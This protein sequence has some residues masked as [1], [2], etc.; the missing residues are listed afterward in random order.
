MET[1]HFVFH[2]D[3][4]FFLSRQYRDGRL[5]VSFEAGQ[6]IKHLV[7]SLGTPHTEIGAVRVNGQAAGLDLQARSGNQV[8]VFA[9]SPGQGAPPE[10]IRFVLDNHLGRLAAALRMVGLDTLYR[11]DYQD[12][13]LA[14]LAADENRILVTRDRRL[15]MRRMVRYGYCPRSLNS[16]EQFLEVVKRFDLYHGDTIQHIMPFARCL[17]CNGRLQ[18]IS[19]SEVLERLEPLTRL[20]Y[21][22]FHVCPACGQIYWK[23][24]HYERMRAR[25]EALENRAQGDE[26][27]GWKP[28]S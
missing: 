19:K 25:I 28:S 13:E 5:E 2:P 3:L 22:D 12:E 21:E 18:P 6:T 16:Q 24:S 10:G 8:E 17:R 1:A 7:E 23:G 26:A 20:Y 14:R 27:N 15:L 11:N 4:P 9:A